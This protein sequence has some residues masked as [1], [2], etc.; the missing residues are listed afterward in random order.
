[1]IE[2]IVASS[3]LIIAVLILRQIF[4][5]KVSKRLQY[6]LWAMV[7]LRLLIPGSLLESAASVG[8]LLSDLQEQPVVQVASGTVTQQAHYDLAFH[9]VLSS[10]D[11]SQDD[12]SALPQS[13]QET[14]TQQFQPEIQ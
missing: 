2:W 5:E 14:I 4:R 1:M 8:N 13:Q 11:Y 12:F 6:A 9:E 3:I 10:H 7:L